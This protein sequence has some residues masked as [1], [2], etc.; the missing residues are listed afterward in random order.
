F[1]NS[2]FNLFGCHTL[3]IGIELSFPPKSLPP[4]RHSC[5]FASSPPPRHHSP[6]PILLLPIHGAPIRRHQRALPPPPIPLLHFLSFPISY[7]SPPPSIPR[8]PVAPPRAP[9]CCREQRPMTTVAPP[10]PPSC[11]REQRPVT[12]SCPARSP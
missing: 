10:G 1:A 12:P 3:T 2:G 11:C 4:P 9:S 5:G 8:P 6:S 7:S